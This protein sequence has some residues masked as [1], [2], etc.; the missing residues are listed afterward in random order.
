MLSKLTPTDGMF[1]ADEDD[2]LDSSMVLNQDPFQEHQDLDFK[3]ELNA[4]DEA[5]LN[6]QNNDVDLMF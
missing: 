5:V 1:Y 2:W 3:V 6:A 4:F